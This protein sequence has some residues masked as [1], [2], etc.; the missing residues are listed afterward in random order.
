MGGGALIDVEEVSG[1]AAGSLGLTVVSDGPVEEEATADWPLV[2]EE[3]A[4]RE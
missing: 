2:T 1:T 3:T 4:G